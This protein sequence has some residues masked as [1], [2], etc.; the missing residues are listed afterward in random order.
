MVSEIGFG[1]ARLGGI[2]QRSAKS[3]FIQTIRLAIDHGITIF[4]TA[5]MYCQGESEALLGDALGSDRA[6]IVIASK[7]G[8]RLPAQ[9]RAAARFKPLV[10]PLIRRLGIRRERLPQ[11]VRGT[12]SQD[13]SRDYIV[14]AVEGSLARLKTDYLDL[15][16]LHSPPAAVIQESEVFETLERLR[17]AGKIRYY[18]VS[19][20]TMDDAL[21]CLRYPGISSLQVRVSLLDQ[22]ALTEAIPHAAARGV[23]IIARECFAGG[24]LT[25][26]LDALGLEDC[27]ADPEEREAKRRAIAE[28]AAV[29]DQHQCTLAQLSLHFVLKT[30]GISTTLLGMRTQAHVLDNLANLDAQ[31]Q[32]VPERPGAPALQG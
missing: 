31:P 27:I 17:G 6:R 4:D 28:Y 32:S 26:P 2:F 5:D 14:R 18:G 10:R 11:V 9:R 3:E 16:Q 13:F 12:I 19:C 25:R 29:A 24:L 8:Y 20:E 30:E 21:I 22:Q 23:A 15:Y 1:C 7:V